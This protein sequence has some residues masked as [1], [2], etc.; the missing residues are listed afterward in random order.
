MLETRVLSQAVSIQSGFEN[1]QFLK[2]RTL[3]TPDSEMQKAFT[4]LAD[5]DS[6]GIYITHYSGMSEWER[7]PSGD[8]FVQVIEGETTLYLFIDAIEHPNKLTAGELFVVPKG[9]WHRFESPEGI[10]VLTITPSPTEHSLVKP[11]KK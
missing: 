5:Y 10:K 3:K 4:K 7:H 11:K 1:V 9:V 6:S 2:N 8:E